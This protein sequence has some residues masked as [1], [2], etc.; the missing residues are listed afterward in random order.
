MEQIVIGEW[1]IHFGDED[2]ASYV[3]LSRERPDG[4]GCYTVLSYIIPANQEV[5]QE[6]D[7][8][9]DVDRV[10]GNVIPE[11]VAVRLNAI[12]L[13]YGITV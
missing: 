1:V 5:G 6:V 9:V 12:L 11:D 13:V 8:E 3:D 7:F 10:A 2:N 4:S